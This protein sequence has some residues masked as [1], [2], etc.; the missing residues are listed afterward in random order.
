M[1]NSE[2]QEAVNEIIDENLVKAW[3]IKKGID[4][5]PFPINSSYTYYAAKGQFE[6]IGK[7]SISTLKLFLME[8]RE[9]VLTK[10]K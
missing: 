3:K 4:I 9:Q 8:Q 2:I 1:T 5:N 6:K 7:G 10:S